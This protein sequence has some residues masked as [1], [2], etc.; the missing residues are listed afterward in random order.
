MKVGRVMSR[1]ALRFLFASLVFGAAHAASAADMPA[2]APL[3]KAPPAI[4]FNWT[5]FYVGAAAGYIWGHSRHCDT[6]AFCTDGFD[7]DGFTAGGEIGYNWQWTNWVFGLEADIS[8]ANAKGTTTTVPPPFG[9]NCGTAVPTC[10]TNLDWFGTVRGRV[11]PTFDRWFPYVTGGF[12]YG[13]LYA[14]LGV[15]A[16]SASATKS[17]WTV[18]GGVEYAIAPQHWSVKLEYLHFELDDLFYDTAQVC[19]RRNCTAVDNRFNVVRLG[20]N[21]RF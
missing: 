12:A 17:G 7:V 16:T 2:K 14:D 1:T 9:F 4:A 21:Y 8:Y 11:G 15:P 13:H 5:G 18:G 10:R 3:Y 6:S 20:V 19:G